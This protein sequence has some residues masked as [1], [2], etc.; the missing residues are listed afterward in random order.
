MVPDTRLLT[1][2]QWLS[3]AFP[4]GAFAYSHGVE[5]A[6]TRGWIADAT[7]LGAWLRD[8]LIQGTGRTDVIWLRLAASGADPE[9]VNAQCRSFATGWERLREADRQ[10][11][12]FSRTAAAVWDLDLP[13]LLLPVAVGRAVD[14]LGIDPDLAA[15]VYL[16][17]FVTNLV[18]A[19]MRLM[20]LGQTDGQRVIYALAPAVL[21]TVDDTRGA[22]EDDVFSNTFL[23][24]VA[25]MGH[26]TQ[27]P[28]LFQ[29]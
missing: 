9:A 18:S 17:A 6:I 1:L 11:A 21:A 15:A 20:P 10:G 2:T 4:T 26:E 29:S 13:P 8:A 27:E 25:A 16:Q 28:R 23:G 3:P 24:D 12:A 14:L 7:G 5:T 19:A 22:T